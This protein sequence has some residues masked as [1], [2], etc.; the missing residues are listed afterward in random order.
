MASRGANSC[1]PS[2]SSHGGSAT[3][4]WT[5]PPG[6]K[7]SPE[8]TNLPRKFNITI[9]GCTDNCTHGESQDI[10][11]VPAKKTGRLGFNVLVGGKM[12]SGGFTVASPLNV[13]VE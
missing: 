4:L 8:F 1:A 5:S 13:F 11:L 3:A 2:P 9:T 10:A 6:S 7:G 12:G